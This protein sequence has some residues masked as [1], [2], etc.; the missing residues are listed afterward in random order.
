MPMPTDTQP[1][2]GPRPFAVEDSER[3]FG[4]NREV[5]EL[6]SLVTAHAVLLLHAQSGAGKSSL[7][8][9]GAVPQLQ[10]EGFEVLPVA[11]IRGWLPPSVRIEDVENPFVYD[12][13]A[14]WA[15]EN[16]E[17]AEFASWSLLRALQGRK[18]G[19]DELGQDAP[20]LLA[21][22]QFEEFFTLYP[23]H[24]PQREGF[25]EQVA[26]VLHCDPLTRVL[27]CAREE[28]IAQFD[29]YAPILP[30]K[31]RTR[32]HLQR[33]GSESALAAVTEP[34][35]QT[36]RTYAPGVAERLV[37]DLI[38]ER[39][40]SSVGEA[41]E[42]VEI[43][44]EFV[45]PVQLQVVCQSLWNALPPDT[46]QITFDHLARYGDVDR[47]LTRFYDD[48][49]AT[50]ALSA[51]IDEAHLRR[52]CEDKLITATGTRAI[53]HQ[54]RDKTQGIANEALA[55][56]EARHLIR[57][58]RRSGANWYELTHDRLIEPIKVGNAA[59]FPSNLTALQIQAK[60]WD[61]QGRPSGLLLRGQLLADALEWAASH[62]DL[63][64]EV[65][66]A[67]V[68]ASHA[69]RDQ[70]ERERREK[71]LREASERAELAEARRR[72]EEAARL[73]AE[74][75]SV[76]KTQAAG[77]LR[78][79]LVVAVVA[80]LI[81]MS[82]AGAFFHQK[83]VA[84]D[85][86]STAVAAQSTAEAQ[87]LVAN[88]VAQSRQLVSQ[89]VQ[90]L[91]DGQIDLALLLGLQ[92]NRIDD[93]VDTRS[94]LMAGLAASPHLTGILH[95]APDSVKTVAVSPNGAT[96]AAGSCGERA[97]QG[98]GCA[99]GA[100]Q[101]WDAETGVPREP[102][103][104]GHGDWISGLAY[105]PDGGRLVSSSWDGTIML[106]DVSSGKALGQSAAVHRDRVTSVAFSP[107]GNTIASGGL[108][109][110][111][112]LW[113]AETLQLTYDLP[114]DRFGVSSVAFDPSGKRLAAGNLDGTVT[115]W[116]LEESPPSGVSLDG[117]GVSIRSLAFSPDGRTLATGGD[118]KVIRLWNVETR[119]E[120]G[121]P[122]DG[123]TAPVFGVA[124]SS[125]GKTLASSS[126]DKTIYLWDVVRHE[127]IDPALIGHQEGVSSVAFAS[128]GVRLV[129]GGF[130]G[131]VMLWDVGRNVPLGRRLTGHTDDV[132]SVA[133]SPDGKMA[134]SGSWDKTIILWDLETGKAIGEPLIGHHGEVYG[135][136][137]SPDG[138]M[139]ASGS[140]DKTV[141]LWDVASRT[142][143]GP[144]LAGHAD[145][146]DTVAFSPDGKMLASGSRD[147]TVILW[148]VASH[149]AIGPPLTGPGD[150]VTSVAFRPDG[151]VLAAGSRDQTI[152]LWDARSREPIGSPLVGHTDW[153][154]SVAFSTDGKLLA[155]GGRD[156]TIRLWDVSSRQPITRLVVAQ[157]KEVLSVAFSPDGSTLASGISDGT[158]VFWGLKA[159][160]PLQP[161]L[162]G[163]D[164]RV[165]SVAYSADGRLLVSGSGDKTVTMRQ[166]AI[167]TWREQACQIAN[168]E[169]T[170][171]ERGLYMAGIDYGPTCDGPR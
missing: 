170:E 55:V 92:A 4:R 160:R 63:L 43:T 127:R 135:V 161:P 104:L 44:G 67:Y 41:L 18:R 152:R 31:V 80:S 109:K 5:N 159:K 98:Q 64:S 10:K 164:D 36:A 115:L 154:N 99:E 143:L 23:E 119:E 142:A 88:G 50:A 58:E 145:W 42:I 28:W 70:E 82:A 89:A 113:D 167:S 60:N 51:G 30:E 38:Q 45:E 149:T 117:D 162:A 110:R 6:V 106:W 1:Y 169:L 81:A 34:L 12:T 20:R 91:R 100:I 118:S 59:W 102:A 32:M 2:V 163:H 151:L 37:G 144:P 146:V 22:D 9:A 137:F 125:D 155:S 153:V 120:V 72:A 16:A 158:I 128:D 49:V 87:A 132:Y 129:S 85:A 19:Q 114:D 78:R 62:P 93:S 3:F 26:E 83:D 56:L 168:R 90:P 11:R 112:I 134:A 73:E 130:D 15:G 46:T 65:E 124:F 147:K 105:S 40:E 101:L 95:D 166:A 123:H 29:R 165:N 61:V 107:D 48:A 8:N 126:L 116:N 140:A 156:S 133:V 86:K 157:P 52:W 94:S 33:L 97:E 14:S 24:W 76:E 35:S 136:A 96:L 121:K 150:R 148:D 71:E 138:K 47:A 74:R 171:E 17:P 103:L 54:E 75:R 13:I 7:L 139:L 66:R 57:I 69:E 79:L 77:R 141:I 68:E 53:V 84:S 21:F 27:F 25:F 108:D 122:L 111:V 39:V 131:E